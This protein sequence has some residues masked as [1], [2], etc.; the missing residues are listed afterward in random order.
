MR[1]TPICAALGCGRTDALRGFVLNGARPAGIF[2]DAGSDGRIF[3]CARCAA[4]IADG[5]YCGMCSCETLYPCARLAGTT[6][7]DGCAAT[8]ADYARTAMLQDARL[9]SSFR[10]WLDQFGLGG[11]IHMPSFYGPQARLL[12]QAYLRDLQTR[13]TTAQLFEIRART[14]LRDMGVPHDL[15][16]AVIG[17]L[18]PEHVPADWLTLTHCLVNKIG[19]NRF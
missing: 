11:R 2:A 12:V 8:L 3:L 17:A 1:G 9:T 14:R 6:C 4:E 15:A 16:E 19:S 5:G 7:C 13:L 18:G 10:A